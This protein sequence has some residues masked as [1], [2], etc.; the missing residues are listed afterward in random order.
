M[1]WCRTFSRTMTPTHARRARSTFR[2]MRFETLVGVSSAEAGWS[3]PCACRHG[4][5]VPFDKV[6]AGDGTRRRFR[7]KRRLGRGV[8][9]VALPFFFLCGAANTRP[10]KSALCSWC[11]KKIELVRENA[12]FVSIGAL[13]HCMSLFASLC[14]SRA[15]LH[16]PVG[17]TDCD[18]RH[19]PTHL[20][21]PHPF[22]SRASTPRGR[23]KLRERSPL[24]AVQSCQ[25]ANK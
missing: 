14:P 4:L 17:V 15:G 12:C 2:R 21:A 9:G 16:A 24:R 18:L 11:A 6:R 19:F 13:V 7:A 20:R 1:C 3:S 8:V 22:E 25:M 23:G 10:V 5:P